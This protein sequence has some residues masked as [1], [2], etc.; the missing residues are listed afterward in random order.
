MPELWKGGLAVDIDDTLCDTA[1]TCIRLMFQEFGAPPGETWQS[2]LQKYKQPNRVEYWQDE[3]SKQWLDERLNDPD[4]LIGLSRIEEA[5]ANVR[6]IAEHVPI[7]VYI[8]SRLKQLHVPTQQW[9]KKH[10]FP[11]ASLVT[12]DPQIKAR[13]WKLDYLAEHYPS[14]WG[15]VDDD[16]DA[17]LLLHTT[18]RGKL[19]LIGQTGQLRE[20][21]FQPQVVNVKNW[22]HFLHWITEQK[23]Q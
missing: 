2:L 21:V 11:S 7:T 9:L 20:S 19:F 4:F 14:I 16:V 15:L 6:K 10:N 8:S 23:A 5:A 13:H 17:N 12:R 18:Y 1:G 22:E 3:Y